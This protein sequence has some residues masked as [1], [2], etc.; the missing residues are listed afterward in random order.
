MIVVVGSA[1]YF[2]GYLRYNQKK[3]L[4]QIEAWEKVFKYVKESDDS[5]HMKDTINIKDAINLSLSLHKNDNENESI[6]KK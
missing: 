2:I 5:L 6:S 3:K 4:K 1:G